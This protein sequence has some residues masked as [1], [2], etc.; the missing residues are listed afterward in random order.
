MPL[1][2]NLNSSDYY[3]I[4][5]CDRSADDAALKKAYRKLAVKWHPDKNPGNEQATKNF[6]KI[7]EAY[8]TLSDKKKR[9]LYDQ[10]GAEGANMSDQMP[11]GPPG[12][13]A[14][15]PGGFGGA[16]GFPGGGGGGMHHMS[17]GDAEAFFAHFFGSEDPFG[18]SFGGMRGGGGSPF[19]NIQT[20]GGGPRGS[21]RMSGGMPMGGDPFSMMFGGGMPG[22]SS[23]M[24]G[25]MPGM[26]GMP[27]GGMGGGMPGMY[28]QQQQQAPSFDSIPPGTVVSLKGLRSKPERNGDRGVIQQY[29]PQNG[30]YFVQLEDSDEV[31]AVK[32]LNLLQHVHVR[33]HGIESKPELNGKTGTIIAWNPNAERY[34]I[35][36]MANSKAVS[37][38]PHNVILDAG[39]VGQIFGLLSK[40]ELNGKWGTIKEWDRNANRYNVQLSHDKIIRVKVENIRV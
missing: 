29:N 3:E 37:L 32:P 31:M 30:R 38:K 4:L 25:G 22:M 13:G 18:G 6:Q 21:Q 12:G 20:Q 24:G 8:A 23:S 2:S 39:T 7:S 19:I 34:S 11:D 33:L 5:G 26:G 10:Y 15:F 17:P 27:M 9:Q 40:P 14:G 28:H 35:Y 36:V 1:T 16:G